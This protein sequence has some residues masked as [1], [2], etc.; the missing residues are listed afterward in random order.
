MVRQHT[1]DHCKM[2]VNTSRVQRKSNR[3]LN[4]AK[5]YASRRVILMTNDV[6]EAF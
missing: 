2:L 5:T 4:S 6:Y 1:G 3:I